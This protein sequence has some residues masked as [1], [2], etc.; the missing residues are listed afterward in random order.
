M[1]IKTNNQINMPAHKHFCNININIINRN[2]YRYRSRGFS[3]IEVLIAI[4]ITSLLMTAVM[5]ALNASFFAYQ[6][7]TE[8]ASRDTIARLIMSGTLSMI[9]TATNFGPVPAN[10]LTDPVIT[11]DYLEM[12]TKKG[13]YI[14]IEYDID[15]ETLYAIVNPGVNEKKNILLSGVLP[16][17]DDLGERIL[18]FKMQYI[19]GPK[20]YRITIDLQVG[21]DTGV[22][23]E[24]EGSYTDTLR[25]V[26]SVMPR[27]N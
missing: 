21:E 20:L 11:S 7:T 18:P 3:V 8:T 23:L 2:I 16:Q 12:L 4:T 24:Q 6:R 17:Y 9:R 22:N 14:R 1:S 26:S 19:I 5:Y 27:N 15:D 13:D 25:I 10:V